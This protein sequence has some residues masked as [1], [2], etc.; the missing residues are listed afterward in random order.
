MALVGPIFLIFVWIKVESIK[1]KL[2][3][4]G[5]VGGSFFYN[6]GAW[7]PLAA[8]IIIGLIIKGKMPHVSKM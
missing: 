1:W 7:L 2:I 8:L 5:I 6:T 4:Y 3:L